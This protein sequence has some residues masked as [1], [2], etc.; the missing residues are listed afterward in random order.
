MLLII[1]FVIGAIGTA[2]GAVVGISTAKASS[3]KYKQE[4]KH[5]RKVANELTEKYSKLQKRYYE[6][7]DESK[8]QIKEF[9]KQLAISEV[10]KDALHLVVELQNEIIQLIIEIDQYP[11]FADI[12]NLQKAISFTNLALAKFD[13]QLI[14][15]P[16][17]YISRNLNRALD[18]ATSDQD[19]SHYFYLYGQIFENEG[20]YQEAIQ[21]YDKSIEIGYF[22]NFTY[23]QKA[24]SLIELGKYQEAVFTLNSALS[25][26]T[27]NAEIWSLRALAYSLLNKYDQEIKDYQHALVVNPNYYQVCYDKGFFFG[28]KGN[29]EKAIKYYD[30]AIKIKHDFAEAYYMR[31][32][33]LLK[34]GDPLSDVDYEIYRQKGKNDLKIASKLFK[35][36]NK[37]I[38]ETSTDH[39]EYQIIFGNHCILYGNQVGIKA[40]NKKYI[41]ARLNDHGK[42][43]ARA[44]HIKKWEEFEIVNAEESFSGNKNRPVRYGEKIAFRSIANDKFVSSDLGNHGRLTAGALHLREWET[45]TLLP[46][47]DDEKL[48]EIIEYDDD[49]VLQIHNTKQVYCRVKESGRICIDSNRTDGSEV[50]TFIKPSN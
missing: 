36:Q 48:G 21:S 30:Q 39:I 27:N 22:D 19:I 1:P 29:K 34:L 37:S 47:K 32:I 5:H 23:P 40:C 35:E 41:M 16:N 46:V 10:E 17:D 6:L 42:L 31:G 14:T 44:D 33:L 18:S 4:A 3:E 45:F 7:A 28:E 25:I 2:V 9:Q 13:K 24:S 43:A 15:L 26:D 11:C 49:F 50:F 8:A 20:K 12:E 38:P